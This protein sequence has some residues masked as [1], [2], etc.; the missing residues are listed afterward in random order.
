[1]ETIGEALGFV[2]GELSD[3]NYEKSLT[4]YRYW[5]E[6][7]GNYLQIPSDQVFDAIWDNRGAQSAINHDHGTIFHASAHLILRFASDVESDH[8]L[9]PHSSGLQNR[10]CARSLREFTRN[11]LMV[12]RYK[13]YTATFYTDV[14]LIAHWANLGYVEEAAVRNHILQS[15]I[16]HPKLYDHQAFALIILFKLAGATFEA[17]V[18]PLVVN[19]CFEHLEVHSAA[20]SPAFDDCWNGNYGTLRKTIQVCVPRVSK[21]CYRTKANFRRLFKRWLRYGSMVGKVSLLHLC[22]RL[23]SPNPTVQTKETPLQLPLPHPSDS[24]TEIQNGRSP[25][26]FHPNLRP[27]QSQPQ[28]LSLPLLPLPSPHP[29]AS[30]LCPTSQSQILPMTSLPSTPRSLILLMTTLLLTLLQ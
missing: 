26:P 13:I 4:F 11:N 23:G 29:A 18:D 8:I 1:M 25:S 15:L 10:L 3:E 5:F 20:Y 12:A 21:G 17:Y 24:P 6:T 7:G 9:A 14:N 19:R 16:S 28:F 27:F 2:V 30:P 22:T